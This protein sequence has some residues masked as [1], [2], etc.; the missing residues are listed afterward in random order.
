MKRYIVAHKMGKE[1]IVDRLW[2]PDMMHKL[3]EKTSIKD[4]YITAKQITNICFS[5]SVGK[6]KIENRIDRLRK[7]GYLDSKIL[8]L[9]VKRREWQLK[10][11]RRPRV[12][13]LS[14]KGEDILSKY[15]SFIN[16]NSPTM[17]PKIGWRYN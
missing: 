17:K 8:S 6:K 10:K 14:K 1:V 13:R 5:S 11:G 15:G 16:P 3:L 7:S 4:T 9:S 2:L 12:Y